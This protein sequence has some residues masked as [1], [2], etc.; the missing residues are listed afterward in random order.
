MISTAPVVPELLDFLNEATTPFHAVDAMAWRLAAAG[1]TELD[2]LNSRDIEAGR[3]YFTIRNNS[4]IIA[5]R[6][7]RAPLSA[8]AR[9]IGAH[10]DS[11]NLSIKPNPLK[12]RHGFVQLGVD[13]YG[14]ALLNPWFD[15][16]LSIAGRVNFVDQHGVLQDAL[17]DFGRAVATIPS[18]AI[19][20]DRE[21]NQNRSVN[22]QKDILPVLLN[23]D[24]SD[25]QITLQALLSEQ[26]RI[27]YPE[28]EDLRII[29]FELS[30]YDV[31]KAAVI[32]LNEEFIASARLDNLLS[33]FVGMKALIDAEPH[34]WSFL[35]CTDHEEVGSSSAIG[36]QGPFLI[37]VLHALSNSD[38]ENRSLRQ[39]SWLLSVDNAHGIHPNF[40]DRHDENHGPLMNGGPVI[41]VNRNQRYAT[42]GMGAAMLK[43]LAES[44]EVPIQTFVVRS[45][46]GCGSTIGPI[47][48][49]E[50]GISTIDLGVPT[51]GMHSVRELAGAADVDYLNRL[52]IQFLNH[53]A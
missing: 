10:T 29:D 4:S 45:D 47:T 20:L 12:I 11:P 43:L 36:A 32:G 26:L 5:F 52:L 44:A 25:G 2:N 1:F 19:H 3:G 16:D 46:L 33:C 48:A 7:G 40:S 42:S 39:H 6:A 51:L 37:D 38:D 21:A 18:L 35:V 27:Q 34:G 24:K 53:R 28:Y 13:V 9:L 17:I 15:R 41:K 22:P 14:G 30:L 23:A 8:G 49:A 31:Q 50:T